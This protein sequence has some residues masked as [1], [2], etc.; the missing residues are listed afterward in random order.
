MTDPEK[1]D[2]LDT[3]N[4]LLLEELERPGRREQGNGEATAAGRRRSERASA[5]TTHPVEVDGKFFAAGGERFEFRGVTYG[6]FAPR[7]DGTLF[8]ER[9]RLQRDLAMMR[10]AGFS[11]VR[12]YTMPPEDLL[13][14][15]SEIGLRVLAGVFYPDWRYL[16]G[17]SR[18]ERRQVAREARKEVLAAARAP[19]RG[20]ANPGA[21]V[22]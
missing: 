14:A 1:I 15:A 9:E 5:L 21:L 10:T 19:G 7:A 11:V 2:T 20:P 17:S 16:L 8:P 6:T 12:T 22:G 18:R 13:E 4:R 3:H